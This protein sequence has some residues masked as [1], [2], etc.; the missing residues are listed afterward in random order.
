MNPACLRHCPQP[1]NDQRHFVQPV[2]LF[3]TG[4]LL[5][6]G[7]FLT[8]WSALWDGF[9]WTWSLGLSTTTCVAATVS[10]GSAPTAGSS[11][12]DNVEPTSDGSSTSGTSSSDICMMQRAGGRCGSDAHEAWASKIATRHDGS[13]T[14]Q[15]DWQQA[16]LAANRY[17]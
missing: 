10:S 9:L 7:F 17:I 16:W 4:F 3:W 15:T 6:Q 2:F 1:Q 12:S 11:T 5:A 8:S 14:S 13:I